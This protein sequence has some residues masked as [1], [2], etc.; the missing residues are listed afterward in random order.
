MR[1]SFI[2]FF[3]SLVLVGC[4]SVKIEQSA[5][6]TV[7]Q[8]KSLT[9]IAQVK[10]GMTHEEVVKILGENVVIGYKQNQFPVGAFE[11]T[12]LKN[13]VRL[14]KLH[15]KNKEYNVAYYLTEIKKADDLISD[16]ELT[17]LVFE[18]G[19]L[20]SKGWDYVFRL[21]TRLN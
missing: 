9:N 18:D 17:P 14:E 12:T 7:S 16:D 15:G 11:P 19:K 3:L 13:P 2:F 5:P 8:Q 10:V 21:K 6:A 1:Q 20:I 4:V